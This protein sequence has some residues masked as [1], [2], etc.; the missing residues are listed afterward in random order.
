MSAAFG[1]GGATISTPGIRALGASAFIAVGTTLPS[2]IPSAASGTLRYMREGL[3]D[4]QIVAWAA[5]VGV[6]TSILGSLLSHVVPGNGHWLMILTALLLGATAWRMRKAPPR[7]VV[8]EAQ[9]DTDA[10]VAG[11]PQH[12]FH[13]SSAA[14]AG[15]GAVAGLLS[16]LL[17]IGGGIV[18]VP[19]FNQFVGLR[20]KQTIATSLVCVGIFAV[21]GMITHAFLG[22]IDWRFALLLAV[23][24]IP[25]ARIGAVLAI[26]AERQQL[27]FAVATF[28]GVVAVIYLIGEVNALLR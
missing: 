28:L 10:V 18:M 2:I 15:V 4:W 21:P 25:G 1:V 23:G 27:R 9:A 20:L 3:V 11:G 8:E 22:D 24:V 12:G 13:Q 7:P 17:G 16:G 19:G 5:P 14:I 6:V 26:R